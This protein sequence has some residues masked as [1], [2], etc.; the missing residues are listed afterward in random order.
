MK[1]TPKIQKFMT[2][3]PHTINPQM[4]AEKAYDMMK[5]HGFRH[6]PVQDGG[7]LVG[8]ITDRDIKLASTFESVS[9]LTVEDVMTPDPYTVSPDASLED[10]ATEMAEHKYGCAIVVQNSK[11]V[12]LFTVTDGMRALAETLNQNFKH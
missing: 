3:T 6:I 11:V 10:V 7:K 8:V 5:E 1:A 9:E 12:G 2:T 4:T